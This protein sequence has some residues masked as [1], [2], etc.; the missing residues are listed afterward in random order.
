VRTLKANRIK[1][2]IKKIIISVKRVLDSAFNIK[3]LVK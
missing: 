2:L 1:V 3:E